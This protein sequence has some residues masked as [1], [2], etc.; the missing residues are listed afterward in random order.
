MDPRIVNPFLQ[1]AREVTAQVLGRDIF[2][3]KPYM[4]KTPFISSGILVIIGMV[5]AVKGKIMVSV[6]Y[7]D[8]ERI[9]E[10][11]MQHLD[12]DSREF[13]ESAIAEFGNM[14]AGTTSKYLAEG[15]IDMII[16]NP[17]VLEG[18]KIK[19]SQQEEPIAIPAIIGNDLEIMFYI[20][21]E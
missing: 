21:L 15:E 3:Q 7:Q 2:Y 9:A 12:G 16:T 18:E 13:G 17:T 1:A 8:W 10:I 5:G 11:M 6:S 14:L 4:K 19:V 20:S